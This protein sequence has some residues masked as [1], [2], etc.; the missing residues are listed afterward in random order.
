VSY[1]RYASVYR[2]FNDIESF[3]HELNTMKKK[4]D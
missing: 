3:M 2:N 1:V 4:S